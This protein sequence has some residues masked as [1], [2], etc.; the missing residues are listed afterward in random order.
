MS[1]TV[2]N[3]KTGDEMSLYDAWQYNNQTGKLEIKE[4]YDELIMFNET[5]T[6]PNDSTKK[7]GKKF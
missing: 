6:D 3:S 5:R 1:T 4:G 2:R 7:L